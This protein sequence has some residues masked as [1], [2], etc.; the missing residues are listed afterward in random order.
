MIAYIA[1]FI[2]FIFVLRSLSQRRHS[3]QHL[4]YVK[5]RYKTFRLREE[6]VKMALAGIIDENECIEL[7]NSINWSIR[8]IKDLPFFAIKGFYESAR[9]IG[10][11]DETMQFE[12]RLR[13]APN[14]LLDWYWGLNDVLNEAIDLFTPVTTL[15]RWQK[16][17]ITFVKSICYVVYRFWFT[18]TFIRLETHP[19]QRVKFVFTSHEFAREIKSVREIDH[20]GQEVKSLS[21]R[22]QEELKKLQNPEIQI[23][24]SYA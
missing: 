16:I 3:M 9:A 8:Y 6:L 10:L 17:P 2:G 22:L 4:R 21:D 5:L 1:V 24:P 15:S 23:Q 12:N 19:L 20:I 11:S 13:K 7:Y 14:E 18:Y